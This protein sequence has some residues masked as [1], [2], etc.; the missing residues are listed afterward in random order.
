MGI[1][2]VTRF[3]APV[4]VSK[5]TPSSI[6]KEFITRIFFY[7]LISIPLKHL[8]L[9]LDN[10]HFLGNSITSIVSRTVLSIIYVNPSLDNKI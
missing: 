5:A 3:K 4:A 10:Q 1:G 7:I 2:W 8:K 9:K 6:P